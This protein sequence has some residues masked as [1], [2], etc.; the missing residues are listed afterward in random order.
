MAGLG[1]VVRCRIHL[2]NGQGSDLWQSDKTVATSNQSSRSSN[3]T[4]G[5][6]AR[7]LAK[8]TG[9]QITVAEREGNLHRMVVVARKGS[10]IV[11]PFLV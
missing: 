8:Q 5:S 11:R 10:P 9:L 3:T 6:F 2:C 1:T 7:Q 4:T